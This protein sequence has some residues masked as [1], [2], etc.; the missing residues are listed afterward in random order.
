MGGRIQFDVILH[1]MLPF[2]DGL[3]QIDGFGIDFLAQDAQ[4]FRRGK[5]RFGEIIGAAQRKAGICRHLLETHA[6]VN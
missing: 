5:R 6:G 3:S 2:S 1:G 4:L